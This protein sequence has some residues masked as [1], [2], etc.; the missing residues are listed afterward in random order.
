MAFDDRYCMKPS[1][2]VSQDSKVDLS[3]PGFVTL[4][5]RDVPDVF[6]LHAF[7]NRAPPGGPVLP[8]DFSNMVCVLVPDGNAE[9]MGFHDVLIQNLSNTPNYHVKPVS[10]RD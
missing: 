6:G 8:G 3:S 9:S 2:Y 4:D 5:T 1:N 10:A 7:D